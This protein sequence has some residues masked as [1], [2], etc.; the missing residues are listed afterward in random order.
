MS[1]FFGRPKEEAKPAEQP[2]AALSAS[3]RASRGGSAANGARLYSPYSGLHGAF[4]TNISKTL[5]ELPAAPEFLFAEE[6]AVQQ[7][8]WSENLTFVTG[9]AYLM[10]ALA[11]GA[12]GAV[13]GLRAPL[14][15]GSEGSKLRLNRVLNL[16]GKSGRAL[17]NSSGVAG[18]LFS[19]VDSLALYARG[20]KDGGNTVFAAA[21][22]GALY[23]SPAGARAAAVWALGGALAGTAFVAGA[24]SCV[25]DV[26]M[27]VLTLCL[28]AT[29]Q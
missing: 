2:S 24:E 5:L 29:Q 10:G 22:T 20:R 15:A 4:D 26:E 19:S 8:T 17:G 3:A 18:L 7:R 13:A 23:K 27:R 1:R 28:Q 11:G 25:A 21:A 12:S 16:G 6:A 9:A 14:P